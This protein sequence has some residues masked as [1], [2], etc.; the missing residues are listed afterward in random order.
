VDTRYGDW[1]KRW[2]VCLQSASTPCTQQHIPC[3]P[4]AVPPPGYVALGCLASNDVLQPPDITE[5]G[6]LHEGAVVEAHLG[7]CLML[8]AAG[9]VWS[10]A[11]CG[12]T[13]VLAPPDAH[14]PSSVPYD[15]RLPVRG[16]GRG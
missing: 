12:A 9:N 8:C 15:L 16:G 5:M 10:V 4:P 13:F 7:Q 6:C 14:W 3:L 2:S 11:N 1:G